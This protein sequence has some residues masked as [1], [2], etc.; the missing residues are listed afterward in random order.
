MDGK[1]PAY[2]QMK[3]DCIQSNQTCMNQG[4]HA[5]KRNDPLSHSIPNHF[6][7]IIYIHS[8]SWAEPVCKRG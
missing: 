1:P 8:S 5:K 4:L 3:T 6:P 7:F 2:F